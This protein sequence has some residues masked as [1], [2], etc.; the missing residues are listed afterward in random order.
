MTSIVSAAGAIE[1]NYQKYNCVDPGWTVK[2]KSNG[3]TVKA[4]VNGLEVLNQA[5]E[6]GNFIASFSLP[7][8]KEV[9]ALFTVSS[10]GDSN[11]IE[12]RPN[13]CAVGPERGG[14]GGL[15]PCQIEGTCPCYGLTYWE[16]EKGYCS[17]EHMILPADYVRK[18]KMSQLASLLEQLVGLY[19]RLVAARF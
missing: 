3:G 1:I 7:D 4:T 8:E 6:A 14:G 18:Q 2:G 9:E 10:G 19:K 13:D 12:L 11:T 16:L 17:A 15:A 5:I